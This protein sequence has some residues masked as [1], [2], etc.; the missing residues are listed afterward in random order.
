MQYFPDVVESTGWNPNR[1]IHPE[2]YSHSLTI[3]IYLFTNKDDLL[4]D[5]SYDD[6][7]NEENVLHIN[8]QNKQKL[9]LNGDLIDSYIHQSRQQDMHMFSDDDPFDNIDFDVETDNVQINIITY[10][11]NVTQQIASV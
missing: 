10:C 3:L 7:L 2:K 6:K 11:N 9:D 4:L 8:N 5:G 1:N